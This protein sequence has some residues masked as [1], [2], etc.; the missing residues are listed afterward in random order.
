MVKSERAQKLCA[1]AENVLITG[2][3]LE[4]AGWNRE[5]GE[6]EIIEGL[7]TSTPT[8]LL[9]WQKKEEGG[10]AP[11]E[12]ASGFDTMPLYLNESRLELVT[13]VFVR[14][15]ADIPTS[16]FYQRATAFTIWK[17]PL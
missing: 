15:P 3:T 4:G 12:S 7:A 9:S 1:P 5:K 8:V 11:G 14:V 2:L 17:A 16:I 13:S 10:I 6:L